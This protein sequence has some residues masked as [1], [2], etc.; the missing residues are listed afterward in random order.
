MEIKNILLSVFLMIGLLLL[1]PN[2]VN[3]NTTNEYVDTST[4]IKYLLDEE[5]KTA[6]VTGYVETVAMDITIPSQIINGSNEYIVTKIEDLAFLQCDTVKSITIPKTVT[7]IGEKVFNRCD[8]LEEI[9]VESA[10]TTYSS[11]DGVLFNYDETELIRYPEGKDETLYIVPPDVEQIAELAFWRNQSLENIMFPNIVIKIGANAFQFCSSLESIIIPEKVTS[12]EGF[13]FDGCTSLTKV[14]IPNSVTSIGEYAFYGCASLTNFDIPDTVTYIGRNAFYNTILDNKIY[15]VTKSLSNINSSNTKNFIRTDEDGYQT[16]LIAKE[17]YKL[18]QNISIKINRIN[19]SLNDYEYDFTTGDLK[20]LNDKI[21]GDIEIEAIGN[22]IHKLS[23][24]ANEGMFLEGNNILK[25]DDA[26]KFDFDKLETPTRDGYKFI[27]Y[28]TEKVG[29]RSL[30]DVMNSEAGIEAD[31]TFYAQW[32]KISNEEEP[33]I[34]EGGEQKEEQE[35]NNNKTEETTITN[36]N[37]PT[38]D[39]PPTGDNIITYVVFLIIATI[40]I[41]TTKLKKYNK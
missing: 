25:F 15:Y 33:P 1:L 17:G 38:V 13:M 21:N 20:I 27:G 36:N 11:S 7:S 41:T 39:N 3:A 16:E 34:N 29:G 35:E 5:T 23:F 19:L 18:P 40:G 30:D 32:E 14:I 4:N 10:N 9:N 37:K 26:E 12:I 31:I 2:T 28:Y 8:N 22:K 6:T 24:D